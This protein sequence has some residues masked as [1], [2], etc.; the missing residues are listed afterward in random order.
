VSGLRPSVSP[1]EFAFATLPPGRPAPLGVEAIGTFH[2][3]EG[4]TLIAP[5]RQLRSAAVQVSSG[6]AMITLN[7][8]SSLEAVGLM[9]A[10]TAALAE[11]GISANPLAGY[12]H[13]HLFVPWG[14]RHDAIATLARLSERWDEVRTRRP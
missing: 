6:F 13:D 5:A 2:E 10:T 11:A 1:I 14:R 7:V 3:A 4:L 8:H 12:F 9:A